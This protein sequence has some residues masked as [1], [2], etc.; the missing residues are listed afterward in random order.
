MYLLFSKLGYKEIQ[1]KSL[2]S[3]VNN[4]IV[5]VYRLL[6]LEPDRLSAPTEVFKTIHKIVAIATN[7]IEKDTKL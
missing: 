5:I 2:C 4:N 1:K 7:F 6:C 3:S